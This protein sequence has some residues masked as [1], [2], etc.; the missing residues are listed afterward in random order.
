VKTAVIGGTFN[1][2]HI[3][4]LYL[5]EEVKKQFGYQRVIFVPSFIPPH[6]DADG[7]TRPEDRLEMLRRTVVDT[8]IVVDDAEIRRGGVSYMI[9]TIKE[10]LNT[11][12]ITGRIGLVIGDDLVAGLDSWKDWANLEKMIDLII[13]HRNFSGRMECRYG[14]RYLDNLVLPISS[15]DIR[16]RV[17][18]GRA[19]R[20]LV[21]GEAFALINQRGLYRDC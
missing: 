16:E 15:R 6:K 8:D 12:T 9:D 13:A 19:Y 17:K 21:P 5:A 14:H 4:H 1:P 11:Y 10:L 7:S 3:G 20:F 2:V 18:S